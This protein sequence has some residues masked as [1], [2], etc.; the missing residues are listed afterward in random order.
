MRKLRT[1]LFAV[2]AGIVLTAVLAFV[3]ITSVK[4]NRNTD[5]K[6]KALASVNDT[7]SDTSVDDLKRKIKNG[8]LPSDVA[9]GI[10]SNAASS[11]NL[12]NK[13]ADSEATVDPT[14]MLK[15]GI[16][17]EKITFL[18]E[19]TD[20]EGNRYT[21]SSRGSL[22]IHYYSLHRFGNGSFDVSVVN[23]QYVLTLNDNVSGS[24]DY[25]YD[26]GTSE[27]SDTSADSYENVSATVRNISLR[28]VDNDS[29]VNLSR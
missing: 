9:N 29:E 15:N 24:V 22:N 27:I 4:T 1:V 23:N 13:G 20:D 21:F 25:Y 10:G 6:T 8:T 17:N 19:W 2:T 14:T 28:R 26:K 12:D 11:N 3:I 7:G 5:S 18:G 16:G